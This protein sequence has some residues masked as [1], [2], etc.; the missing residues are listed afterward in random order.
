VPPSNPDVSAAD[1]C[2]PLDALAASAIA[3]LRADNANP[4]LTDTEATAAATVNA[5]WNSMFAGVLAA[6]DWMALTTVEHLG[7]PVTVLRAGVP[8]HPGLILLAAL[9]PLAGQSAVTFAAAR[10]CTRDQARYAIRHILWPDRLALALRDSAVDADLDHGDC[11]P[12]HD[13]YAVPRLNNSEPQREREQQWAS[14]ALYVLGD[15]A[16]AERRRPGGLA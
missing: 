6:P 4:K 10:T 8:G 2:A 16:D 11:H 3:F 12:A 7:S 1:S 15:T 5:V 9:V 13:L 14:D